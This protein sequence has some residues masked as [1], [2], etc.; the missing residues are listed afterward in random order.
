MAAPLIRRNAAVRSEE[1]NSDTPVRVVSGARQVGKSTL[2]SQLL[3][4]HDAKIFNLDAA[5]TRK[6]AQEDPDG[7]VRPS[8]CFISGLPVGGRLTL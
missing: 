1:I 7:F 2:V 4:E 5:S 8:V 3:R 6:A